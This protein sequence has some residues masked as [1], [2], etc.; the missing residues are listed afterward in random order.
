MSAVESSL[1]AS[2]ADCA[3][4]ISCHTPVCSPILGTT[5]ET[6]AQVEDRLSEDNVASK[7]QTYTG[8]KVGLCL[9][10]VWIMS[11]ST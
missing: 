6:Q 10:Y 4:D 2:N 9:D 3:D 7:F 8:Q 11:G 5:L 1:L